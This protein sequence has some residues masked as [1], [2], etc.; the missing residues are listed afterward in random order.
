MMF[1]G[2]K[3]VYLSISMYLPNLFDMNDIIII[4][5]FDLISTC[6]MISVILIPLGIESFDNNHF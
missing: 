6:N 1:V 2:L 3:F 4:Y 5:H